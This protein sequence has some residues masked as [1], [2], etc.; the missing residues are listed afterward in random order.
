MLYL[1]EMI[2]QGPFIHITSEYIILGTEMYKHAIL[3]LSST[4]L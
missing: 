1:Q 2:F 4:S 3:F